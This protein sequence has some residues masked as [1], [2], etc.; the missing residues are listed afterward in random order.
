LKHKSRKETLHLNEKDMVSLVHQYQQQESD[1]LITGVYK[2]V[3]QRPRTR[4]NA[5]TNQIFKTPIFSDNIRTTYIP[6]ARGL[7]GKLKSNVSQ[8][9]AD[10]EEVLYLEKGDTN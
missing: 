1:M 8:C 6:K 5:V 2:N 3:L 4:G 10:L 7:K 9:V